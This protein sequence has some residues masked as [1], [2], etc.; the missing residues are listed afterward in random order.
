MYFPCHVGII[1]CVST[2][3]IILWHNRFFCELSHRKLTPVFNFTAHIIIVII[4]IIIIII[5][6]G[7]GG[8]AR[9]RAARFCTL[10]ITQTTGTENAAN[11]V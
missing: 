10:I 6:G 1:R 11:A 7:G 2:G 9:C 5:M 4:I 3:Y 8:T